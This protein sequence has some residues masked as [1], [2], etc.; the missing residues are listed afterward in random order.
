[1]GFGLPAA[2]G[3]QVGCP[4]RT[5]W[6]IDGDGSLQMTIQELAT[7]VQDNIAVKIAVLNN[8][9][10]GMVRQWQDMFYSKRYVATKLTC[11]DFV[12]IA[13]A[14]CIPGL[15]V[16]SRQ[17]VVPAIER[18]MS[19]PGPFLINFMVEPEENVYPMVPPGASLAEVMEEPKKEVPAWPRRSTP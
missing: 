13:E 17:E 10:L 3:A 14:Y 9:Y 1:M 15:V 4:D 2:M 6:C 8:G 18:A 11:P 12:K 16:K 5:V 19:E 7:I